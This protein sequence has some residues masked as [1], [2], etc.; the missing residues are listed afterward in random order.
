MNIEFLDLNEESCGL[1][2]LIELPNYLHYLLKIN[3]R[4]KRG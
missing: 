1:L 3:A 2:C 4:K